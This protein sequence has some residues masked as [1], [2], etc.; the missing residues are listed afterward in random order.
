MAVLYHQ[1]MARVRKIPPIFEQVLYISGT[2]FQN[3][4]EDFV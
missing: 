2:P 1:G 3:S 4:K